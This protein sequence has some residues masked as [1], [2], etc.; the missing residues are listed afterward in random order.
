MAIAIAL[1][2]FNDLGRLVTP[3]SLLM[4]H[5]LYGFSTFR[6]KINKIDLPTRSLNFFAKMR[7]RI[8]FFSA[9]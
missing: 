8:L 1:P 4:D 2:P 5:F 7:H 9:I 3:L 6:E